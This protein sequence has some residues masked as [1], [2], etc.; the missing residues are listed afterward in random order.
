MEGPK[1]PIEMLRD[2]TSRLFGLASEMGENALQELHQ[3][4]K[5]TVLDM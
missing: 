2:E 5:K 3:A 1:P 4:A